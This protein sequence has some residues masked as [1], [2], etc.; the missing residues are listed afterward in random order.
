MT[1]SSRGNVPPTSTYY[2]ERYL[3]KSVVQYLVVWRIMTISVWCELATVIMTWCMYA[4]AGHRQ[5]SFLTAHERLL[6]LMLAFNVYLIP[7]VPAVCPVFNFC[8]SN[9]YCD[10]HHIPTQI[11]LQLHSVDQF[12]QN[13][14]NLPMNLRVSVNRPSVPC[15]RPARAVRS[16]AMATE[17]PAKTTEP[18]RQLEDLPGTI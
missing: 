9:C 1:V 14:L 15:T 5:I 11:P 13:I 8:S 6:Q 7:F 4:T 3:Q 2:L 16:R 12:S 17:S 10:L 18:L